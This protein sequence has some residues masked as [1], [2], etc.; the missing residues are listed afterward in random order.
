MEKGNSKGWN[1]DTVSRYFFQK[2]GTLFYQLINPDDKGILVM[3]PALAVP[4]PNIYFKP[5]AEALDSAYNVVVIEP[6]GYGLSDTTESVRTIENINSELYEALEVLDIDT[7]IL[8]VHSIAGI[9]GLHFLYSYLE[10]VNAF[11]AIDNTVY[12]EELS[13]AILIEQDSM[14]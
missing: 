3:P 10:K 9:Y 11:I 2:K 5:L 13:E 4:S 6:F 1:Y 12:D 8:L 7:C 14:L